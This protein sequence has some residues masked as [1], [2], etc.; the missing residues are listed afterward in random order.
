MKRLDSV[1]IEGFVFRD[2]PGLIFHSGKFWVGEM[3]VKEVYN[4]GSVAMVIYGVKRGKA[5]LLPILRKQAVKCLIE[6]T[7][8]PF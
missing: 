2:F 5:K 1:K 6:L 3:P 4:N 8:C 7:V